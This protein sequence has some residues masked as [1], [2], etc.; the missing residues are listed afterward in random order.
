MDV[1]N[2]KFRGPDID[3][4]SYLPRLEEFYVGEY[5]KFDPGVECYSLSM[6]I[7][8]GYF[9]ESETLK[10]W[11]VFLLLRLRQLLN[12]NYIYNIFIQVIDISGCVVSDNIFSTFKTLPNISKII[13]HFTELSEHGIESFKRIKPACIVEKEDEVTEIENS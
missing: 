10:V 11:L 1:T 4:A 8:F 13:A 2:T 9:R 12:V 6:D 7:N 5:D 3:C